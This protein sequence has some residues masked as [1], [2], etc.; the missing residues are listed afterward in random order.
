MRRTIKHKNCSIALGSVLSDLSS[1]GQA[2]VLVHFLNFSRGKKYTKVCAYSQVY[3]NHWPCIKQRRWTRLFTTWS[4]SRRFSVSFFFCSPL[5]ILFCIHMV[6]I[7]GITPVKFLLCQGWL[8]VS[9]VGFRNGIF[10][11]HEVLVFFVFTLW[12]WNVILF[13]YS[14]LILLALCF[15]ISHL[16]SMRKQ[17]H[18]NGHLKLS[19]WC[20]LKLLATLK[21]KWGDGGRE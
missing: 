9:L 17:F 13:H 14:A 21:K 6:F 2:N 7:I 15:L 3:S 18:E 4:S 5:E 20:C 10:N 1:S 12:P 11:E 8:V 16:I 19:P